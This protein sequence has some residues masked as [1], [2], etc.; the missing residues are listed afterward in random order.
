MKPNVSIVVPTFNEEENIPILIRG[1]QACLIKAKINH[2]IIIVDDDSTDNTKKATLAHEKTGQVKF[3]SRAGKERGLSL[4]VME[5]FE[6]AKASICVVMDADLSHPIEK[7]PAMINPILKGEADICVGSRF[8]DGGGIDG[9]PWYRRVISKGAA[10]LSYGLCY[11]T[12]PTSGFMSLRKDILKEKKIDPKSWKIVLEIVYKCSELRRIDIP[13]IFKD[14]TYGN[15]KLTIKE[16]LAY[17]KHLAF[18]YK[19]KFK[20]VK[21]I[22]KFIITGSLGVIVDML[23]FYIAFDINK[24]DIRLATTL[25]FT[26]AVIHNYILNKR[27]TFKNKDKYS[28]KELSLYTL[29]SIVG[30]SLR[31]SIMQVAI[32][33]F[34]IINSPTGLVL[35]MLGIILATFSN[36]I[37]SQ[38]LLLKKHEQSNR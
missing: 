15:S 27:W 10:M 11:M 7:L 5:G 38:W 12:D 34:K 4:S 1:I 20:K 29:I 23:V 22:I 18:L 17:I 2:E 14:R 3:I 36:Y 24:N 37:G 35:N 30:L 33:I 6:K 19:D 16:Q 8:I 25:A 13:I 21:T 32:M 9:W 31:L 26:V 28:V